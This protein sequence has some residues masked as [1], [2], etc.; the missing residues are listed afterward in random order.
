MAWDFQTEPE[1]EAQLEWMRGFVREEIRP[2]ETL[3]LDFQTF[4]RIARP[5]QDQ[6]KERGLWAAHLGPELGGQSFGQVKLDLMHEI[7]GTCEYASPIFGNQ[8]P[9]SGNSELISIAATPEH[10]TQWLEP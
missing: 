10:C 7:L 6:V 1:F 9:D 5:L 4:L 3:D 8:A 2:L